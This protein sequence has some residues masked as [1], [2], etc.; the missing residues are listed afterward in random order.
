MHRV[1]AELPLDSVVLETDSPDMAPAMHPYQ[2]NSPQHLPDICEA[3]AELMKISPQRLAQASTDNA[4][5][6]FDWPR[7]SHT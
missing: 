6:L 3:I 7:L 4:C 2:R 1:I 5:E